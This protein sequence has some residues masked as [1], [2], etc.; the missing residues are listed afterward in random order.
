LGKFFKKTNQANCEGAH[1]KP[2]EIK[3]FRE[4]VEELSIEEF[5]PGSD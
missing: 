4:G 1:V 3:D 5:D 2:R